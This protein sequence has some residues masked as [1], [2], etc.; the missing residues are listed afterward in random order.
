VRVVYILRSAFTASPCEE[1][2]SVVND[3][4]T[5]SKSLSF[6]RREVMT[7]CGLLHCTIEVRRTQASARFSVCDFTLPKSAEKGSMATA[8]SVFPSPAKN[9]PGHKNL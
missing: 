9:M 3:A 1:T 7:H 2:H 4:I 6:L 5:A 8:M